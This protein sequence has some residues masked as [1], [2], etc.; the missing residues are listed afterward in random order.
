[1]EETGEPVV[2][3]VLYPAEG[4]PAYTGK[5]I[6]VVLE[7]IPERITITHRDD[8]SVES[9]STSWTDFTV[10][11]MQYCFSFDS[12]C[13]LGDAWVPYTLSPDSVYFGGSAQQKYTFDVDWVGPRTLWAIAQF[14][15]AQGHFIPS[16]STTFSSDKPVDVSQISMQID[17][18]WNEATPILDQ[19]MP[20]Q[21]AIAATKTAYPVT[22][23]VELANGASATGGVVGDTIQVQAE[24]NSKSP[25]GAVTKMRVKQ[26]GTCQTDR[27]QMDDATW[28]PFTRT[29]TFSVPVAINWIGFYVAVQYQ[30]DH[31]NLS[32][33]YCDDISVEGAPPTPVTTP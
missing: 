5:Q 29:R 28:E 26:S 16:F 8:G 12:P 21:T 24:F 14:R 15:D 25:F 9:V 23:S 2:S 18:I 27:I 6:E 11:E 19:P 33:V 22:G 13:S 30:D 31:G 10:S 17:A 20:V 1:V 32:P 7:A 3:L 4:G